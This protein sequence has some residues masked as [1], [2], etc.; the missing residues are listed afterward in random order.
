MLAVV[1]GSDIASASSVAASSIVNHSCSLR[2]VLELT[3]KTPPRQRVLQW[4]TLTTSPSSRASAQT[5]PFGCRRLR[6]YRG[7]NA[8]ALIRRRREERLKARKPSRENW[9]G[10]RGLGG[11]P[12]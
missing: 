8:Q 6:S 11:G 12:A 10:I 2:N 4:R 1:T 3:R 9:I 7:A 5:G